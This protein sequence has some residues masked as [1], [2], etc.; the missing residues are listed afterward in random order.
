MKIVY[1]LGSQIV[2]IFNMP[3]ISKPSFKVL[4]ETYS[5]GE[6]KLTHFFQLD[7]GVINDVSSVL[8]HIAN[9]KAAYN[10]L[11]DVLESLI[12]NSADSAYLQRQ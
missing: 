8:S 5:Q 4:E 7:L 10:E 11:A 6:A 1:N 2:L 3:R 9:L 12:G